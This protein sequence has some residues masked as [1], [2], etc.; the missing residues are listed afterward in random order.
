M[1]VIVKNHASEEEVEAVITNLNAFGFD[2]LFQWSQPNVL[3]INM[4][5]PG[6]DYRIIN[7]FR[8]VAEV[9]RVTEL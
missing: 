1:V 4:V 3:R 5:W 8:G 9:Q 7:N 6:F 2:S